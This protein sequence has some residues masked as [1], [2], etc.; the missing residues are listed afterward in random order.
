MKKILII[1]FLVLGFYD[2]M[3]S[4]KPPFN[5]IKVGINGF[6]AFTD[7]SY[8]NS[9]SSNWIDQV[10]EASN[11]E[12][13]S[14]TKP[15][16]INLEYGFQP[17]FIVHPVRY[18]QVGIKVD[19][20]YSTH[21]TKFENPLTQ[22]YSLSVKLRSYSPGVFA[23]LTFGKFEIGGG[24]FETYVQYHINDN[25]FGYNDTWYGNNTGYEVG[26]GFSS[27][28][29]KLVGFTMSVKYRHLFI[30][31]LHDSFGR[32][33]TFSSSQE[34][35]SLKMSG[36]VIDMGI[37]FQFIKLMKKKSETESN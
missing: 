26:L 24:V 14:E 30:K 33:V 32:N 4:Q 29:E 15:L 3:Y 36:I 11:A 7:T 25:F 18:L 20:G 2:Q 9:L 17:F 34:N 16:P 19:I 21:L 31:E 37:Y 22:N 6:A 27:A 35:L 8:L 28:K 10:A 12:V 23:Y 13:T 1:T 5:L